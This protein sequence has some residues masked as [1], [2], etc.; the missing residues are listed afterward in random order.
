M[1]ELIRIF[2]EMKCKNSIQVKNILEKIHIQNEWKIISLKKLLILEQI[3]LT[4]E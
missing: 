3:P 2:V 4:F 1:M